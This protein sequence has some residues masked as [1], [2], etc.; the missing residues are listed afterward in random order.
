MSKAVYR[1]EI[2][3]HYLG[4]SVNSQ[5]F[6]QSLNQSQHHRQFEAWWGDVL[7]QDVN[8][9]ILDVGCGWGGFL[10]FLQSRGYTDLAGVDSSPQQ[11]EIAQRLGL[12]QVEVGDIFDALY[13]FPNHYS[14]IIAFN[15]LEHLDKDQVLPFLKAAK[16]ALRPNGCLLLELPNSNSP[17]GSRTRYWDFTHELSFTPTSLLQIFEVVGFSGVQLRERDPVVHGL[18]SL[19]RSILW[20]G[21]RQALGFY[22]VVEQGN[23]GYEVFTQDMHAIAFKQS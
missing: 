8:A 2:Y 18:K 22:L 9:P 12:Q 20:Q 10:A 4:Q 11:V 14:C 7:P 15:V 3:T 17:F 21:I 13:K 6:I 23:T 1:Q 16:A 5:E 19:V